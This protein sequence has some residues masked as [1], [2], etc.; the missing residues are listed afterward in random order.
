MFFRQVLRIPEGDEDSLCPKAGWWIIYWPV[1]GGDDRS[2]G[3]F[4]SMDEACDYRDNGV[5]Q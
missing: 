4:D 5:L 2:V 1:E 3:P